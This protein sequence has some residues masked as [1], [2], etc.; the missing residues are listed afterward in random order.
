M[1]VLLIEDEYFYIRKGDNNYSI[2][3][4]TFGFNPKLLL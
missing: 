4:T 3:M 1:T 2:F